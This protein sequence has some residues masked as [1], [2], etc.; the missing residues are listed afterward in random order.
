MVSLS[1]VIC[2]SVFEGRPDRKY[3][4]SRC[5]NKRR[6][7][8]RGPSCSRCG[9][10]MYLAR[11]M[12]ER[13]TCQSCRRSRDG[14]RDRV[15]GALAQH[16][17]CAACGVPCSRPATKGQRPKWCERCRRA[18]QNR[19]IKI[20]PADRVGVYHRDAWCCWLCQESVD[21]TLIGSRSEWRPSLDHV[22]P[23][24]A[25]GDDSIDNLRLAH[26]WCNSVRSDGRTYSPEDF[27]VSA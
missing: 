18:L 24:S 20:T 7:Q 19:D 14:Y 25:G 6:D 26:W 2:G 5:S 27:R 21:R 22:I 4:S 1:C 9:K 17:N 10:K 15:L 11:V 23:R 3:C 12:A 16:W 13:P 8:N